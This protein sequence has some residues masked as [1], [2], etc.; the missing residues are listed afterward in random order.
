MSFSGRCKPCSECIPRRGLAQH[1]VIRSTIQTAHDTLSHVT[2]R[3]MQSPRGLARSAER[4]DCSAAA[5]QWDCMTGALMIA[6]IACH[7]HGAPC[8]MAGHHH[9]TFITAVPP[10]HTCTCTRSQNTLLS[11]RLAGTTTKCNVIWCLMVRRAGP[12]SGHNC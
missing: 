12:C 9:Q 2:S 5:N 1:K 11:A 3:Y 8:T 6:A 7:A 4:P 10:C